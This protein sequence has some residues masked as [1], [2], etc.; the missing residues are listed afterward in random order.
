MGRADFDIFVDNQRVRA[1]TQLTGAVYI[2]AQK[3][4]AG[5]ALMVRLVGMERSTVAFE[6]GD[7][8]S[9]KR[10]PQKLK[11]AVKGVQGMMDMMGGDDPNNF[12]G[13]QTKEAS[14]PVLRVEVPVGTQDMIDSKKI[15]PGKYKLP[16]TLDLPASL[17]AT[18]D[19]YEDLGHCEIAYEIEAHLEGS[20]YFKD[21]K[22]SRPVYIHA[23]PPDEDMVP[24]PF[25]GPPETMPIKI[26]CCYHQGD[27]TYGGRMD[28]T[29]LGGGQS[30]IVTM[31]GVNNS[32]LQVNSVVASLVQT[33]TWEAG[34]HTQQYEK[35]LFTRDFGEWEDLQAITNDEFEQSKSLGGDRENEKQKIWQDLKAGSHKITIQVPTSVTPTYEGELV[36]VSHVL[37]VR[38]ISQFYFDCIAPCPKLEIPLQILAASDE[39]LASMPAIVL[40]QF[41][42]DAALIVA[43]AVTVANH[44]MIIGGMQIEDE[45]EIVYTEPIAEG[46]PSIAVFIEAMKKTAQHHIFVIQKTQDPN[47]RPIFSTILANDFG[48]VLAEVDLDFRKMDVAITLARECT[49]FTCAHLVAGV[50]TCPDWMRA[51]MVGQLLPYCKDLQENQALI[52]NELSEWD[53]TVTHDAFSQQAIAS[54]EV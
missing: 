30:A 11:G 35:M 42:Y 50:K 31:A 5:T 40:P 36:K 16:F 6:R 21:Y 38:L 18:M 14:R 44:Q 8:S 24:V 15:A 26:L 23:K 27:M 10:V 52:Q 25:E 47:W 53:R 29:V 45:E 22:T 54:S 46:D 4:I 9:N 28:N 43:S 13:I 7:Y 37:R 12:R 33:T 34:G 20:G 19:V 39:V 51:S 32:L 49:Y 1:G 2:D 17:P 3:E 48:A 41:A